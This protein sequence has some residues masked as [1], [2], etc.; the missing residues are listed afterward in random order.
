MVVKAEEIKIL[1]KVFDLV[2]KELNPVE[3]AKFLAIITPKVGD[4]VKEI[5]KFRDTVSEEEFM[6][7]LKKKGA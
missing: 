1:E 6:E 7:M 5:R 4:S 3:Y 2:K